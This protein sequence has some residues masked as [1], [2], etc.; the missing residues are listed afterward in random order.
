MK[1]LILFFHFFNISLQLLNF[2]VKLHLLLNNNLFVSFMCVLQ[3]FLGKFPIF[4]DSFHNFLK[5]LI[6]LFL[7]FKLIANTFNPIQQFLIILRNLYIPFNFLLNFLISFSQLHFQKLQLFLWLLQMLN[8]A[9]A[10][11]YL[12]WYLIVNW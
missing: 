9:R 3:L 2:I 11:T 1:S 8:Y 6:L 7:N 10:L 5:L 4:D 12:I